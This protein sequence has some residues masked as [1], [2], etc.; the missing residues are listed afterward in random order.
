MKITLIAQSQVDRQA[1]HD[2][3]EGTAFAGSRFGRHC[4]YQYG[5]DI[6]VEF[7]GRACYQSWDMPNPKTA[8]PEGYHANILSHRH[9]SIFEHASVTF[10][11]E[12][13]SRSL[14]AELTRHRH[15]SF[16]VLSQRFVD[17]S[18]AEYVRPPAL[19]DA[20]FDPLVPEVTDQVLRPKGSDGDTE[21]VT[22]EELVEGAWHD[23]LA[24]Y[25]ALVETLTAKGLSRKQVREA[26][27]A[28]LPNMTETRLVVTGNHRAWR[29][30]IEK[31]VSPAADAEIK[32]FADEV[33]ALVRSVAPNLYSDFT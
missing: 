17:S 29:E 31:R 28:V 21:Q 7:A 23:A 18:S 30:V 6:L 22:V 2:L 9:F 12:G 10:Y 1:M 8:T 19:A 20:W 16:S 26:A 14:L 32:Q 13:V 24:A 4:A 5:A 15:L 33:L 11:V 27:R 3:V 25:D